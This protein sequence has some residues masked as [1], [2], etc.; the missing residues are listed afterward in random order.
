MYDEGPVQ[1]RENSRPTTGVPGS[2]T[3]SVS[4]LSRTQGLSDSPLVDRWVDP[5]TE[6]W[7]NIRSLFGGK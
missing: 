3:V 5:G 1:E 4:Y 6:I 2:S 7:A